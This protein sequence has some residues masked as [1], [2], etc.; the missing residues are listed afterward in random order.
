LV[1]G[2]EIEDG[3]IIVNRELE[4]NTQEKLELPL[5]AVITIQTGINDP[6]YVSI[7]GIRK[8]RNIEIK[9]TDVEKLGLSED[10][11]GAEGSIMESIKLSL[12]V[13]GEGAEILTGS[14][15]EICEKTAQIIRDKG[16]V[17]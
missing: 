8:V 10:E 9:E 16:G 13:V 7:M 11:I 6:R 14:L 17:E 3:K 5:P 12:P 1:V 4:S 15:N 2:I